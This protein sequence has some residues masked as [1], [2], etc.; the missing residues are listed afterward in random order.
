MSAKQVK[1]GLGDSKSTE[2]EKK[3]V[4]NKQKR[5]GRVTEN[6]LR[7]S[8]PATGGMNQSFMEEIVWED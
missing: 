4:R 1:L 5:P 8:S 7:P 2:E 3:Q 6:K